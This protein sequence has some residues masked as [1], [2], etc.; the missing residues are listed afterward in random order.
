MGGR[1]YDEKH[2][3]NH[4]T[5]TRWNTHGHKAQGY[6]FG[7]GG[8]VRVEIVKIIFTINDVGI[9]YY[10]PNTSLI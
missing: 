10:R 4:H 8:N 7:S 1:I 3:I 6:V 5:K 9:S 2:R